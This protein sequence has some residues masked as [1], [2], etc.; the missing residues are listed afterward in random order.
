VFFTNSSKSG[1]N[2]G[3][4]GQVLKIGSRKKGAKNKKIVNK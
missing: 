2:V 1:E 4:V 3:K